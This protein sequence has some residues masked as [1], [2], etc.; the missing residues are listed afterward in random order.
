MQIVKIVRDMNYSN[1]FFVGN[2]LMRYSS[3]RGRRGS[4]FTLLKGD[5]CLDIDICA[6]RVSL[7]IPAKS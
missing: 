1:M 4:M 3:L 5:R 7:D 2:K 6:A